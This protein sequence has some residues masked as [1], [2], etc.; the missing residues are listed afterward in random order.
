MN[1][2][3]KRTILLVEDEPLIAMSESL[4]LEK[5]GFAVTIARTGENAI[6][7]VRVCSKMDLILMD[8]DLGPGLDGVETA[9][10]ILREHEIPIVFLSSRTETAIVEKTDGITSYGYITKNSDDTGLLVSIRTA[11]GLF[12]ARRDINEQS[13][14]IPSNHEETT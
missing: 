4:T 13:A 12:E 5:G 8:I 6:E 7:C 10:T 9:R 14:R 3:E 11:L 2:D 1:Q